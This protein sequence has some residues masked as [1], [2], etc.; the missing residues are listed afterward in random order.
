MNVK[1]FLQQRQRGG[2]AKPLPGDV[3]ATQTMPQ[4][5]PAQKAIRREEIE[6]EETEGDARTRT[7]TTTSSV[8]TTAGITARGSGADVGDGSML[9]SR[10]E[11]VERLLTSEQVDLQQLRNVSWS[12]LA[13]RLR[14]A[15]WRLLLG[16]APASSSSLRR[17]TLRRTPDTALDL[18]PSRP[19]S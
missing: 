8:G 12:G 4:S 6:A 3:V 1:R 2:Q 17:E 14:A 16:Y 10:V 9:R 5:W 18:V 13:P 15:S 19:I 11:H 7:M